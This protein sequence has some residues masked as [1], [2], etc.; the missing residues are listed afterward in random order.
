M[1]NLNFGDYDIPHVGV[2]YRLNREKRRVKGAD[3]V[4]FVKQAHPHA[5]P[6]GLTA[7][8]H[9]IPTNGAS[10]GHA[11]K[12]EPAPA[13][14]K[15]SR[16]FDTYVQ[17][18]QQ[19][20]LGGARVNPPLGDDEAEALQSIYMHNHRAAQI[21]EQELELAALDYGNMR[22]AHV[23]PA[24]QRMVDRLA[25]ESRP[26]CIMDNLW[27]VHAM[28]GPM[29]NLFGIDP[30]RH[31]GRWEAWHSLA[32]KFLVHSPLFKAHISI[33]LNYPPAVD[34]FF[35]EISRHLFA[36]QTRALLAELHRLSAE[37]GI[38]L[39]DRWW[40]QTVTFQ[41]PWAFEDMR[42]EIRYWGGLPHEERTAENYTII[43]AWA[44]AR[45][46]FTVE[47]LC[48]RPM[49]YWLSLWDTPPNG[50]TPGISITELDGYADNRQIYFAADYDV[51]H[52]F[53]VNTWPD[54][55]AYLEGLNV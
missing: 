48:G 2:L 22:G 19:P 36:V 28:N 42:R 35:K 54:V 44:D 25:E 33:N 50:E 23:P 24:L 18:L 39:F 41:L 13:R 11:G 26:A 47:S 52:N 55:W 15:R 1:I 38:T 46:D 37:N 45:H 7:F 14:A 43:R 51:D 6:S 40:E 53:H 4:N 31:L 12:H 27:F 32:A 8:E 16:Y 30:A 20:D 9:A 5:N 3:V 29:L 17:A 10:N 49:H 34:F 21:H